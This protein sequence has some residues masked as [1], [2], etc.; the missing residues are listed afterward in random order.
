MKA[1][2]NDP[3]APPIDEYNSMEA[4]PFPPAPPSPSEAACGAAMNVYSQ[5]F[6]G[7]A[8]VYCAWREPSNR[9]FTLG[10]PFCSAL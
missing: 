9:V 8:R 3:F 10:L 7:K 5:C 6:G 1:L 4:A 2:G